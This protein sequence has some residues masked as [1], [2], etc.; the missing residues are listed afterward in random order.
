MTREEKINE[1]L[2]QSA[3]ALDDISRNMRLA[4]QHP[5]G[6]ALLLRE[7]DGR[8]ANI[9]ETALVLEDLKKHI[10]SGA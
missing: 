8:V 9:R 6:A 7:L 2:R 3:L 4:L 5:K 1:V 10:E